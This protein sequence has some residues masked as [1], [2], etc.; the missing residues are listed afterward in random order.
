MIDKLALVLVESDEFVQH[1][2]IESISG[3]LLQGFIFE[4]A[5]DISGEYFPFVGAGDGGFLLE[6][7]AMES[8]EEVEDVCGGV[9]G[10]RRHSENECVKRRMLIFTAWP[11]DE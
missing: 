1:E 2:L 3:V 10:G 6:G 8:G 4:V 11:V 9:D 5:E 7:D